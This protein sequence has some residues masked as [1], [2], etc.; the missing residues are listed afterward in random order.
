MHLLRRS[1]ASIAVGLTGLCLITACSSSGDGTP[2]TTESPSQ[3]TSASSTPASSTPKGAPLVLGAISDD[4]GGNGTSADMVATAQR[5][6]AY[7]NAHGGING[8]PVQVIVED[9]QYNAS[10]TLQD[11]EELI[12]D[13]HAIAILDN[14]YVDAA[15]EKYVDAAKVPV[16]PTA[17]STLPMTDTNF[18][19][20]P[21]ANNEGANLLVVKLAAMTGNKRLSFLYCAEIAQCANSVPV[22]KEGAQAN[23]ITLAYSAAFSASA[24]NYTAQCLA[25][26]AAGVDALFAGGNVPTANERVYDDCAQQGY[27]PLVMY[28]ASTFTLGDLKDTA[29]Q[30]AAGITG[31]IPWFVNNSPATAAFQ[32]VMG[33]YLPQ[34]NSAPQTAVIWAGLQLFA[35]AAEHVSTTPTAAEIYQGLYAFHGETLGG[36]TVPLTFAQGKTDASNCGFAYAINSGKLSTPYGTTPICAAG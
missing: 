28:D 32:Q 15:F 24:P 14:T 16:I 34:A 21:Q 20:A 31:T 27:R 12:Q 17:L 33:D 30:K 22:Y 29:V 13:K 7:V 18:Q 4:S 8:H 3:T 19:F 11:A 5:W 6:S 36:L 10:V 1:Y 9:S 25:A 23:K 26:K 35:K 2:G